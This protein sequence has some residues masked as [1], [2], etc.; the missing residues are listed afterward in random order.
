MVLIPGLSKQRKEDPKN[1][2]VNHPNQTSELQVHGDCLK[3]L[4]GNRGNDR[5]S[6][7]G[8]RKCTHKCISHTYICMLISTYKEYPNTYK[9]W[10]MRIENTKYLLPVLQISLTLIL[11]TVI[12]SIF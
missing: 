3:T 10:K 2:P 11:T 8:L 1:S 6:V 4:D 9:I 12:A 7:F 5:A